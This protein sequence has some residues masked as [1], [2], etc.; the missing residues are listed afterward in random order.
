MRIKKSR[1]PKKIAPIVYDKP[2]FVKK[3]LEI[4]L[5]IIIKNHNI[6][7]KKYSFVFKTYIEFQSNFISNKKTIKKIE[8][9]LSFFENKIKNQKEHEIIL[10]ACEQII[11]YKQIREKYRNFKRNPNKLLIKN[12]N[13]MTYIQGGKL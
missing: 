3:A 13:F 7:L 6:Y 2:N 9:I 11:E 12:K 10:K 8:S 5:M 4:I 1:L